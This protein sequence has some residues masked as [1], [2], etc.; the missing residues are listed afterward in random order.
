[1]NA[2]FVI[3]RDSYTPLQDKK[4]RPDEELWRE[5]GFFE[6]IRA[7]VK[8]ADSLREESL[9][10]YEQARDAHR[11]DN[12]ATLKEYEEENKKLQFLIDNGFEN[13]ELL[14]IPTVAEMS[15]EDYKF[16]YGWFDYRVVRLDAGSDT[17]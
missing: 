11:V 10:K 8:K 14:S 5:A 4:R 13:V 15:L 3:V 12:E 1:M 2:I 6:D 16:F 9:K 7:A 17:L